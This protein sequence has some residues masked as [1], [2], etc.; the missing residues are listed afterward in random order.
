ML[1][2]NF[3]KLKMYLFAGLLVYALSSILFSTDGY[4]VFENLTKTGGEV[5]EGMKKIIFAAAGFGIIAVALGAVFGALNWKWLSVIIIGVVII[6]GTA[7]LLEYLTDVPGVNVDN[8]IYK[9]RDKL[10]K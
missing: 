3:E 2:I 4:A 1:K 8:T 5:F 6:A 9:I 7:M 10:I